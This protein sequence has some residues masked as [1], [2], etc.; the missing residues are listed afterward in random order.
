MESDSRKRSSSSLLV[1]KNKLKAE[2]H[3][4][5]TELAECVNGIRRMDEQLEGILLHPSQTAVDSILI[6]PLRVEISPH[7][8]QHIITIRV[9]RIGYY[10]H[11]FIISACSAAVLWWS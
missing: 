5:L 11:K 7:P 2:R 10:L 3:F 4:L 1:Y 6:E 8:L 9:I